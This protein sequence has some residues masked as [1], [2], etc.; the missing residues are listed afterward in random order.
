MRRSILTSLATL[1]FAGVLFAQAPVPVVAPAAA[2]A[3]APKPAP[4]ATS[5]S[6]AS[7]LQTLHEMKAANEQM[8]KKQA[9]AL[10]QLDELEKIAEQLRLYT[11]RS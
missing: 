2:P 4:V 7:M 9:A 10:E 8:L 1:T 11:R 6:T 5:N 3:M